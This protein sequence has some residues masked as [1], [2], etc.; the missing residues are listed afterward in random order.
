MGTEAEETGL[1]NKSAVV[2]S[3]HAILKPFLLR[4]LK[5]DVEKDLPP[6]KEYLLYAPLTQQQKDIY[7]AIVSGQIRNYLVDMKT[8]HDNKEEEERIKKEKEEEEERR[9]K[10]KDEDVDENGR[11]LRKKKRVSYRIEENDSKYIRDLERG[12]RSDEPTGVHEEKSAAEVGRE[13]ALKQAS[14]LL[15]TLERLRWRRSPCP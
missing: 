14:E 7:Q 5:V 8:G 12:V 2:S 9:K 11:A 3:L 15:S 1:L 13:W 6:K 4:R 10:A